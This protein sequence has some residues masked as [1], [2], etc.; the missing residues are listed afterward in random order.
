MKKIK[1]DYIGHA[2]T[3][4]IFGMKRVQNAIFERLKGKIQVKYIHM[5]S[6]KNPIISKLL[7]LFVWPIKVKLSTRRDAVKYFASQ[8]FAY[9]LNF[10]RLKPCVMVCYDANLI[11]RGKDYSLPIKMYN[12]FSMNGV[13]KADHVITISEF[14]K[15]EIHKYLKVPNKKMTI[16]FPSTDTKF[17]KPMKPDKALLERIGLP[18]KSKTLLYVGAEQPKNNVDKIIKAL[19]LVVKKFPSTTFIKV[20]DP[21]WPGGRENLKELIKTNGLEN[22]VI[23]LD[24]ISEEKLRALYNS[25]DVVVNLVEYNGWSLP[26]QEAMACGCP[27]ITSNQPPMPEIVAD[28]AIKVNPYDIKGISQR[29]IQV[30]SDKKLQKEL[31]KAGIKRARKFNW[32]KPAKQVLNIFKRYSK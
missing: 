27:L 12:K 17:F 13:K 7:T 32:D 6:S 21:V 3:K 19:K 25:V 5:T 24:Y 23:F 9:V 1:V 18:K 22:N 26:N 14:S 8:E 20:G 15:R 4:K 31:S 11:A 2:P 28:A 29:I 16:T 10:F 30:L